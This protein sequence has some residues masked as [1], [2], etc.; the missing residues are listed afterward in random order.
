MPPDI[1]G[2]V[3]PPPFSASPDIAGTLSLTLNRWRLPCA[4]PR[5]G[6][7]LSISPEGGSA[8]G[9][10]SCCIQDDPIKLIGFV[11]AT[12]ASKVSCS[13]LRYVAGQQEAADA[14]GVSGVSSTWRAYGMGVGRS[15]GSMQNCPVGLIG[16]A[17][18]I[19]ASSASWPGSRY[20]RGY[21]EVVGAYAVS[22]TWPVNDLVV[23]WSL[24]SIQKYLPTVL[25]GY[26]AAIAAQK[27]LCS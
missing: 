15:L 3:P 25:L 1:A 2:T 18:A 7:V 9:R 16:S 14:S 23:G 5:H 20:G 26:V 6:A 4:R 24:G 17:V 22:S 21:Q 8:G 13:G 12:A 27:V 11:A 10:S 19:A